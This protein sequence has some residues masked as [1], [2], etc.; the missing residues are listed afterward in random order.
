MQVQRISNNNTNFKQKLK[1]DTR[2][3]VRATREEKAELAFIKRMFKN[4]GIKGEIKVKENK[5][6][7]IQEIIENLKTK[8][9]EAKAK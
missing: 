9:R 5:N 2:T 7:S 3:I 6:I 1:F 4:N 8:F